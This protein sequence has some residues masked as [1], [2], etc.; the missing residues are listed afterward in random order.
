MTERRLVRDLM[1]VG[2]STC[3]PDAPVRDIARRL[4]EKGIE[5]VVVLDF[6][7][8]GVGM[9]SQDELV[10]AYSRHD[11]DKLVAKDIMHDDVPE[12][13]PDIPLL[14]AA[15]LMQ[16]RGVRIFFI[17]H[18]ADGVTYP[19]ASLSY[20]HLL[21]HLAAADENDLDDLGIQASRQK[22]LDMFL[23]KRD[24][25]RRRAHQQE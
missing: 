3:P 10:K 12:I 7:G 5:G 2:V 19:A 14:V 6:E 16:D 11:C 18:H 15:Q 4:L 13:P 17:T 22:P 23:E 1:K 25:A 24:A 21:R 20:R 9:V 8:H